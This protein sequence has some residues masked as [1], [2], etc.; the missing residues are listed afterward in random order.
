M[1]KAITRAGHQCKNKGDYC[2]RH[3]PPVVAPIPK[4]ETCDHVKTID[5][6][7][8]KVKRVA[9]EYNII[10]TKYIE[11]KRSVEQLRTANDTVTSDNDKLRTVN[12]N[13]R[14]D[15]V[16]LRQRLRDSDVTLSEC[17]DERDRTEELYNDLQQK[18]EQD[19]MAHRN[20]IHSIQSKLEVLRDYTTLEEV[21]NRFTNGRSYREGS[22]IPGINL[23]YLM[24]KFRKIKAERNLIAHPPPR[25]LDP[26][27]LRR[28]VSKI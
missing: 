13:L 4:Q 6:L 19:D 10:T 23:P 18:T 5:E 28:M 24:K 27:A 21:I 22:Y 11:G 1:C 16:K 7:K 14:T 20:T 17:Q 9:H 25:N 12:D 2:Y 15:I 26:L 3:Q 8:A